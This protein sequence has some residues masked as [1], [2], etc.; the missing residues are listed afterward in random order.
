MPE[1]PDNEARASRGWDAIHWYASLH[2][3]DTRDDD[4]HRAAAVDL[5]TD[6]LHGI[7]RFSGWGTEEA[8]RMAWHHYVEELA[9]E[10]A[11]P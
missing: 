11:S 2:G 10:E 7:E 3:L 8:H 1:T 9:E 5:L 6:V 4:D